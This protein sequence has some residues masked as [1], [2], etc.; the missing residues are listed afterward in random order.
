MSDSITGQWTIER[1]SEIPAPTPF[2][3][4]ARPWEFVGFVEADDATTAIREARNEFGTLRE[5]GELRALPF[6]DT[7]LVEDFFEDDE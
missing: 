5:I 4:P 3:S 1:R 6:V 7:T 2:L